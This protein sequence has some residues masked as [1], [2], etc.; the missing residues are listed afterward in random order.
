MNLYESSC[1]RLRRVPVTIGSF[2]FLHNICGNLTW[3]SLS[4]PVVFTI[5]DKSTSLLVQQ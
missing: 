3:W 4:M 5:E 1:L 2:R